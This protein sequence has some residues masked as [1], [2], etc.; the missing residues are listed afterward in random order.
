MNIVIARGTINPLEG[1]IGKVLSKKHTVISVSIYEP[2]ENLKKCF[3]KSVYLLSQQEKD[4]Q[5][6]FYTKALS[7]YDMFKRRKELK[8]SLQHVDLTIGVS[9]PNIFVW[10]IFSFTQGK[11]IFFPYDIVKFRYKNPLRNKWYDILF[12]RTNFKNADGILH[13]GPEDELDTFV[14]KPQLQFLPYCEKQNFVQSK[15]KE[16]DIHLVYVG[17]VYDN[18][19]T[20]GEPLMDNFIKFAQQGFHVHI[21]PTAY[22]I[23][24]KQYQDVFTQH[25]NIH[26]HEPIYGQQLKEEISKYHYGLYFLEFNEKIKDKWPKTVFGNKVSDYLE[27]G[28]P[29]LTSRNLSFVSK[30]VEENQFGI[31]IPTQNISEIKTASYQ[32]MQ[33]KVLKNREFFTME[34]HSDKLY[35][36][37]ESV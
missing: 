35:Q 22:N 19:R 27:A 32:E 23:V 6:N 25:H 37:L 15:R 34:K 29:I 16:N 36:F 7:M 1:K 4:K 21:Y 11:K 8:N 3:K 30:I 28:L 20:Q 31:V 14:N 5:Y 13:K 10:Y 12:E 33:K 17:L 18:Y 2:P 9:E 26:L 24:K